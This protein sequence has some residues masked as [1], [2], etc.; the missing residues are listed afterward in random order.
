MANEF[1]VFII[2]KYPSYEE[3]MECFAKGRPVTLR[4]KGVNETAS[5][6]LHRKVLIQEVQKKDDTQCGFGSYLFRGKEFSFTINFSEGK[7]FLV[8]G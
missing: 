6:I 3:I 1:R 7:G 8:D 2:Q 4:L 5:G